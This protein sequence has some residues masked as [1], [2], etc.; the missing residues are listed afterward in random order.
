MAG[1][2]DPTL[3]NP[4]LFF[5]QINLVVRFGDLDALGHV[6]HTKYLTYMEQGRISYARDILGWEG[7]LKAIGMILASATVDYLLPLGFG[8]KFAVM[9]RCTRLGNKSFDMAY[10]IQRS[11]TSPQ[12]EIAATGVTRLVAYAYQQDQTIAI[13][14][15]WRERIQAFEPGLKQGA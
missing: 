4:E 11:D 3:F 7:D 8:D 5:H 15:A 9:T 2:V 10:L 13:P 14:T 12:I 6:N 1:Q